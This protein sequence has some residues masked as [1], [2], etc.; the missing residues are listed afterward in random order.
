MSEIMETERQAMYDLKAGDR[1]LLVKHHYYGG[2][3]SYCWATVS[4]V[5][6]K[7]VEIKHPAY[8]MLNFVRF[9]KDDG[10]RIG[11]EM[12]GVHEYI[13]PATPGMVAQ[14]GPEAVAA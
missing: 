8:A 7:Q 14:Y 4:K 5:T 3:D 10:G 6:P 11:H 12:A 9:R 1:V 13:M 2:H